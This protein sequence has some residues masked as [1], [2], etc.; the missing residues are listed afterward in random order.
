MNFFNEERDLENYDHNGDYTLLT[1][2]QKLVKYL[3]NKYKLN[4]SAQ[5]N[6][7]IPPEG[8]FQD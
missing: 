5:T 3:L 2:S 1:G 6:E 4:L 7:I 8:E